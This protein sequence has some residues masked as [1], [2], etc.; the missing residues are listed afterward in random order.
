MQAMPLNC[1]EHGYI[2]VFLVALIVLIVATFAFAFIERKDSTNALDD[3]CRNAGG[4]PTYIVGNNM[5]CY[6]KS[7]VIDIR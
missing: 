2:G 5:V 7:V 6:T 4:V 1:N 3:S